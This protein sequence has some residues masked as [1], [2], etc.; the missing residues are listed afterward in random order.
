MPN[1]EFAIVLDYLPRG[2]SSSAKTEPIAQV[3]GTA[4]FSLL[5]VVPKRE[6]KIG[7]KVYIG[8][9]K[10]ED[11]ELVKRRI[12]YK[13]LTSTAVGELAK[14][15][16]TVV[17]ED[18][19][20]FA[21]FL[22]LSHAITLRRHQLELLPGIGQKNVFLILDERQKKPFE[23]FEDFEKRVSGM[24]NTKKAV[25][26]RILTELEDEGEKHHVFTRPPP[27]DE[28]MRFERFNR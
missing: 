8:K 4:F 27:K 1:E 26:R 3:L 9:D 2:K 15:V 17:D 21:D 22:N 5:E 11:I 13:E 7:S 19:K 12:P 14:A 18:Q 16:E 20:R 6:L 23:S 10:R 24:S 25:I 28:R